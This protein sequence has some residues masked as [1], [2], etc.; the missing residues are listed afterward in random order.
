MQAIP[1]RHAMGVFLMT[2]IALQVSRNKVKQWANEVFSYCEKFTFQL[3][4]LI[5][6]FMY[7]FVTLHNQLNT[8]LVSNAHCIYLPVRDQ[9]FPRINDYTWF[10][11]YN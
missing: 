7:I 6:I 1:L 9:F 2:V 3:Y 10:K 11:K 8:S 5:L 4:K